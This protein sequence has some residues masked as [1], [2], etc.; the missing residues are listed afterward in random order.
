[1]NLLHHHPVLKNLLNNLQQDPSL[2]PVIMGPTASGKSALALELA[3]KIHGEIISADSMQ[4]YRGLDIGTAKPSKEDQQRIAHHLIDTLDIQ[5]KA[6]IFT[7]CSQAEE[8]LRQIRFKQKT[9]V[10][11]GGSGLYL[12]AFIYG[13]DP[14]PAKQE[15]RDEL[16]ARYD[17]EDTFPDLCRIMEKTCP[18]DF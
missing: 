5:E 17:S 8:A 1:M 16:D 6:D 4:F 9:P 3:E 11:A 18:L 15:L 14:L 7:F 2:C 13:L 10:V 12:R